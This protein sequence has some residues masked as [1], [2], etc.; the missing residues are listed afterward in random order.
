MCSHTLS[1]SAIASITSGVKSCGCG[2][3]NRIRRSPSTSFTARSSSANSGRLA[4][5]GTVRSRPY[6]LTFWP[7][8]V[9]STTPRRASPCTSA[10]TSP[11]G[12]ES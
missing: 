12:R 6:V 9:I 2:L 8:S 3:V 4:D 10:R 7:S 11:I 5:S 1:L